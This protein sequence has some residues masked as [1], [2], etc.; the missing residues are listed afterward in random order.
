M[1]LLVVNNARR[2]KEKRVRMQG[3][4]PTCKAIILSCLT[5]TTMKI[6]N[7]KKKMRQK[8]SFTL[9]FMLW[10]IDD[11]CSSTRSEED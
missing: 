2:K 9:F 3:R 7:K 11:K 1:F 4:L 8:T 6:T 10:I 5:K